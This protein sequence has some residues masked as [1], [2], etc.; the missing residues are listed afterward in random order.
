M[1]FKDSTY[2]VI[3]DQK[4]FNVTLLR[5]DE[6]GQDIVVSIIPNTD[7]GTARCKIFCMIYVCTV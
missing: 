3:E 2:S 1:E 6:P 4:I 7:G 5:Q